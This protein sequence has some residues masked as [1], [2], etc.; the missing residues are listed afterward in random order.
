MTML[1]YFAWFIGEPTER[2]HRLH[3]STVSRI[4][5]YAI[6]VHIPVLLWFATGYVISSQVF[7]VPMALA[8]V[9]AAGCALLVYLVERIVLETPK[10]WCVNLA[11][12]A[13]GFVIAVIGAST[14]D[15]VM[16]EREVNQQLRQVQEASIN[17]SYREAMTVQELRVNDAKKDWNIA[18]A[19]ANCE[20]DGTCGSGRKS[21]GPI[22][23][24][25]SRQ[26]ET[27]RQ[28]YVAAQLE[29]RK[30]SD[31]WAV[32]ASEAREST[33]V[34]EQAGLLSRIEALHQY[35]VSNKSAFATWLLFFCLVLSFEA[36]VIFVK[37]VFPE[38]VDDQIERVREQVAAYRAQAYK[39]AITSPLAKAQCEL[40]SVYQ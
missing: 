39:E 33:K 11:R 26:A 14:V 16:F 17:A 2:L 40:R 22:Y 28:D 23:R 8:V 24:E 35:T 13:I 27:L 29:L 12:L 10:T 1:R 7:R 31:A 20:A 15:L 36:M 9:I 30:I 3:G 5:A 25:L 32:A 4:K 37:I 19:A 34:L 38:T 21:T 6:A 18:K